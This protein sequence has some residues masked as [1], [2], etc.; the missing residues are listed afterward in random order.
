[1]RIEYTLHAKQ[2]MQER[3][4]EAVWVEETIKTPDETKKEGHKFYVAKRLNGHTLKVV[5]VKETFIKVV[6]AFFLK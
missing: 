4:V 5:Y 1:M 6:T 3:K 2:Q